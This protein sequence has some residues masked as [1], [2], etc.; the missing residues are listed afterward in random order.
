MGTTQFMNAKLASEKPIFTRAKI[1]HIP[2]HPVLQL[3]ATNKRIVLVLANRSI[4]RVDQQHEIEHIDLTKFMEGKF[5]VHSAHLD[6][7]GNH[8]FVSLKS[9]DHESLP[10]VIYIPPKQ[11]QQ[12][13]K[14]RMSTK[15][16]GHLITAVGWNQFNNSLTSTGPI[17]MGT[18]R[19]L[20]F[21][22]EIS[23]ESTMFS[24]GGIEKQWKQLY[25]LG[26]G[27][28][29]NAIT[30]LE[31]HRVPNSK[32]YFIFV[33]TSLRLY[34][35][36]GVVTGDPETERPL[37]TH[38]FNEYLHTPDQYLEMPN[39]LKYSTLSF[40][41]QPKDVGKLAAK[42]P[43][44]PLNFG[45][46][47]SEGIF[48]G[49]INPFEDGEKFTKNCQLISFQNR[50][51][52]LGFILTEFHAVI[53]FANHVEGICLL[54]EQVVFED[55]LD[56][57]IR[58]I[59]RDPVTGTIYVF[60]DYSVH[61]YNLDHEDK[62]IWKVF[63]EKGNFEKS[64][65]YC[66]NDEKKM[67]EVW[68]K[69]AS[70]LFNQENYVESAKTYAK[71]RGSDF[72]SVALKFLLIDKSDALLHY[73]KRRLELV[74]SAEKTQLTMIIVWLVEIYLN[75]M[76]SKSNAPKQTTDLTDGDIEAVAE[77]FDDQ[78][79]EDLLSM[80][81]IPKVKDCINQNRSTFYSLLSS[82]GDKT[83][84]I[85]FA[86]I[87][88]DHDR[89]IR[90]HLQDK[91]F[92]PV[93]T[94]L[95]E[96]LKRGK[97]QLFYQYGPKLMQTIPR[98]F[99]DS[100]MSKGAILSPL[101][102]I[103]SLLVNARTDQELEAIRYLEYCVEQLENKDPPVHNY[104]LSLYIKHQ[105]EAVWP[106]FQRF[107][108]SENIKY[109]VK[110]ALR[111]CCERAD[112]HR[113]AVYLFCVLGHLEEAVTVAL[114]QLTLDDAKKCLDF[115]GD[116]DEI[117]R[118]V[119]LMIAKHVVKN[120]NDIKQAMA[121]LQECNGLVKVEDILPFFPNFVTIDHF[122]DAICD[123]LQEYSTHIQELKD[124]ME[125]AYGSAERIRKDMSS[126]K[127]K[128]TFV[129]ATDKCCMCANHLMARPFHLFPS[130]GHKFHT[131]CL[132]EAVKPHLSLARQRRLEELL[133]DLASRKNENDDVQSIDSKTLQ[134]QSRKDELRAEVEDLIAGECIHCG[135]IMIKLID[136]PFIEDSEFDAIN[137]EWL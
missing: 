134:L 87:M 80:M 6:P 1:N 96:Q 30:G 116:N 95:E 15:I 11:T 32:R 105:P 107:K 34:Q 81:S 108:G 58:G 68:T 91:E 92:E 57:I 60:S 123:S 127:G 10:D 55:E 20:I 104:L 73:L 119:W 76:G 56:S 13:T 133:Q 100:L 67:D 45:W 70:D 132:T 71:T 84:L 82:H 41:Y 8:L 72:E 18:T 101:K 36:Q 122:K 16:R 47:T 131:D 106:Y 65:K 126:H 3:L 88:N 66:Y 115:A 29:A 103:P 19:G 93:L 98:R 74:K 78:T 129:R 118:K 125:E 137:R 27:G 110:Y 40:Y 61:K 53:A 59:A 83:N 69:Q 99:V 35:F 130:C 86:N 26:K 54:N 114:E 97:P 102:L 111:L 42:F 7:S 63:L 44:Y 43:L 24:T 112:M 109:D 62:H 136:K 135:D 94:V 46:M 90:Y 14:P 33:T 38:V 48:N 121:C 51:T 31:Y 49:K 50:E 4:Q 120:E 128:Y 64:L 9:S 79:S 23:T 25:D 85:K 2:P 117:K 17:L 12:Q 124:E 52:P 77:A 28:Q 22:T 21:E 39:S 75:K 37:L 5:K 89:V 113:E